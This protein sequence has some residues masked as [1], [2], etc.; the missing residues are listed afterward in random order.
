MT[1]FILLVRCAVAGMLL[2][3]SGRVYEGGHSTLN[4]FIVYVALPAVT[5]H[6]L[7]SFRFDDSQVWPGLMP[8]ALFGIGATVFFALI[9]RWLRLSRATV[10]ALTLVGG[11]LARV[12]VGLQLRIEPIGRQV[13][14]LGIGLGYKLLVCPAIVVAILWLLDADADMTTRV[15]VIEAAVPPMTDAGIVAAQA[16]ADGPLVSSL[17]GVGIPIGLTTAIAWHWHFLHVAA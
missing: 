3:R 11:P 17:I 4:P 10:G 15:S 2:R 13:Q 7:H 9:G 6:T 5:L 8:C 14:L 12:S 1:N 16:K